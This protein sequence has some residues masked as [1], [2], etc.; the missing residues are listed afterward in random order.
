M[1]SPP[2]YVGT[3]GE[4]AISMEKYAMLRRVRS[5]EAGAADGRLMQWC[6]FAKTEA[7]DD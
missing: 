7:L 1:P 4:S 5:K 2:E 3:A 6:S